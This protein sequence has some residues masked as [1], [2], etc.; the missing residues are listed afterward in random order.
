MTYRNSYD[1]LGDLR[2]NL[3]EY[4]TALHQ[5]TSTSGKYDNGWLMREGINIAQAELYEMLVLVMRE[6][7][8][9]GPED[10][11]VTSSVITL[12]SDFGELEELRD[13]NG[14][15]VYRSGVKNLPANGSDGSKRAYYRK[16]NTL[17]L[18]RSGITDTY[19]I[20]YIRKPRDLDQGAASSGNTLATTAVPV[21]D[22]Y[23]G[24]YIESITGSWAG[25]ISDYTAGRVITVSGQTLTSGHYYGII[26]D[27]PYEFHK[28]IVPRATILCKAAHPSSQEKPSAGDVQLWSKSVADTFRAF[29]GNKADVDPESIW[30]DSDRALSGGFSI[31]GHSN[32]VW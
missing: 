13:G 32:L 16:G 19:S 9:E 20:A 17:V 25:E 1:M 26:S 22:Y 15:K 7:F 8:L 6:H 31:P 28:H 30:C 4:S 14:A 11:A 5:G 24:M 3:N 18:N 27:L 21:D 2:H 12:P 10:I 29:A 23:N